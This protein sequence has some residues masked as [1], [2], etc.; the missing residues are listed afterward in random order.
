[1]IRRA[2]QALFL[3]LLLGN[4]THALTETK[5]LSDLNITVY[6]PDWIWQ[7][8][9]INILV[10]IENTGTNSGDIT[11]DL[12][13]PAEYKG[14]F[15]FED[16]V[17]NTQTLNISSGESVRY[18][19]TNIEA[20]GDV[21]RQTYPFEI[22]ISLGET[23]ATFD[24]PLTTIRGPVVSTATWAILLPG[25]LCALWC[26]AFIIALR[27][28]AAPDAWKTPS[29]LDHSETPPPPWVNDTP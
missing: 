14:H 3:L 15:S 29:Q 18:A 4:D 25:I 27:K 23:V 11:L 16:N 17:F 6:A 28:F 10:T 24:Y 7:K 9:A 21:P 13:L 2:A 26:I 1:M 12:N 8:N 5:N 20:L 19:F 22:V